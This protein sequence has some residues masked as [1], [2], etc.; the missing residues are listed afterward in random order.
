MVHGKP[1]TEGRME[2][3]RLNRVLGPLHRLVRSRACDDLTDDQLLERFLARREDEAFAALVRRHGPMVLAVCQRVL[4]NGHDA[5]DA[6]QATFFVLARRAEAVVPGDRLGYWLHGVARR[7]ALKA[8]TAAARR[9]RY[10]RGAPPLAGSPGSRAESSHDL[11][12][13]LDEELSRLPN[14]YGTPMVL[15]FLEG[16]SRK[17]VARQLGWSEGT[18]SGRL[19]RAKSL[20]AARLARRGFPVTCGALALL[21]Q[22]AGASAS[23]PAPIA[24]YTVAAARFVA[25]GAPPAGAVSTSILALT[26]EVL[27]TML[28]TKIK[29]ATAVLLAAGLVF[30]V[31]SVAFHSRATAEGEPRPAAPT[32]QYRPASDR[33]KE[34]DRPPYRIEP[35][36]ILL[37]EIAGKKQADGQ[38][39]VRPD[40]TISL[41]I[42]GSV[43]VAGKTIDEARQT[44]S[45]HLRKFIPDR[46]ATML[47]V[48]V[49]AYNSQCYYV[50]VEDA[51][52]GGQVLRLP[53][54]G[55][56]TVLDAL[57]H[58]KNLTFKTGGQSIRLVRSEKALPVDWD[59]LTRRGVTATNYRLLAG[60]RIFVKAAPPTSA[61]RE[62]RMRLGRVVIVGNAKTPAAVIRWAFPLSPGEDISEADLRRA[63]EILNRVGQSAADAGKQFQVRVTLG[64]QATYSA[65]R[66]VLITVKE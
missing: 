61:A 17:E 55:S 28:P 10:E 65:E 38:H 34:P 3:D 31:G 21:L 37:V 22:E 13:L 20:L 66:N 43:H 48:D 30:G 64:E 18:L 42:F 12:E 1:A 23:V 58:V 50:I 5:E 29:V 56:D 4:R 54:T 11:R 7:T 2:P 15:C 44:I 63:E 53:I 52:A 26:E 51:A 49:V 9:R 6:F 16:R 39:L 32:A 57:S 47:H 24:A 41:G 19:A 60:D 36:D 14:K 45:G 40:G 33:P 62:P 59:G 27:Q 25:D 35:P 46:D 8:K